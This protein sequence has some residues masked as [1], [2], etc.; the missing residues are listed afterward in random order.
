M[1]SLLGRV[2]QSA[3]DTCL[4]ADPGVSSLIP[5]RSYTFLEIHPEIIS[6]AILLPSTDSRMVFVSYKRKYVQEVLVNCLVKLDQEKS[7]VW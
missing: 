1:Q 5:A 6:M 2:V 3:A 7:V 4:T